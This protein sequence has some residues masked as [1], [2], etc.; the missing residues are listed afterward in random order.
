[1]ACKKCLHARYKESVNETKAP[2][3]QSNTYLAMVADVSLDLYTAPVDKSAA[4]HPN[5]WYCG[6]N[7]KRPQS[8]REKEKKK[9]AAHSDVPEVSGGGVGG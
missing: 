8:L 9:H 2:C 1:M 7:Q 4:H 3:S 5:C 6:R